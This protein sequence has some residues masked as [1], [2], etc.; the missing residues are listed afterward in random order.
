MANDLIK[1]LRYF[2]G[3]FLEEADFQAEQSY[4]IGHRRR[5]NQILWLK[6]GILDNG[7]EVKSILGKPTFILITKGVG[8]DQEGRELVRLN[9]W[10][11]SL[12]QAEG[13][14]VV[15]LS[16]DEEQTDQQFEDQD[17]SD[18]TRWQEVPQ[19]SF[20]DDLPKDRSQ[21]IVLALVKINADGEL[22]S[23]P[24]LSVRQ[25]AAARLPGDLTIGQDGNG[26]LHT[27]HIDGKDFSSDAQDHLFLNYA[28]NKDVYLGFGNG[29]RSSLYVSGKIGVGTQSPN[30]RLEIDMQTTNDVALRLVSS[31][32]GWGSGIQFQNTAA[33]TGR[34]FGIYSNPQGELHITDEDA[35]E[36]RL[37]MNSQKQLRIGG[38]LMPSVGN[39]DSAGIL[40]PLDPGG[41]SGDKAF[42][43]YF[44]ETGETTKLLIGCDNDIDDRISFQQLGAERLTIYGG[45]IGIG[46]TTPSAGKL[47]FANEAGN[48]IVV[49]DGGGADRYGFGLASGNLNAFIPTGSRFSLRKNGYEGDEVFSIQG[50]GSSLD[51]K[52]AS[53]EGPRFYLRNPLKNSVGSEWAIYNMTG[54]Y[55]DSLQF[56]NYNNSGGEPSQRLVISDDGNLGIGAFT[57]AERPLAGL[58]INKGNSNVVAL[59]ASSSG[60]G[61]GSGLQLRNDLAGKGYGIYAGADAS[62]HIV[63]TTANT[64][65]MVINSAG[66]ALFYGGLSWNNRSQIDSN[67]IVIGSLLICWGDQI[68]NIDTPPNNGLYTSHGTVAYPQTFSE[69]PTVSTSLNDPG[70][71]I[72]AGDTFVGVYQPSYTGFTLITKR[73]AFPALID[74]SLRRRQVSGSINVG[75]IAIGKKST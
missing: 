64:D 13:Q 63:D 5:A 69:L 14:K 17:V 45:N 73:I 31:G 30:A 27:R 61:W 60:P 1:R 42:I 11:E 22:A 65:R 6:A 10:E 75:W 19:V 43:R 18:N 7:F 35:R 72:D 47:Q 49:W 54:D 37:V 29:S 56:W 67:F 26:T 9:D 32:P 36:S 59:L 20:A 34:T 57:R 38:V 40:F 50:S 70:Y 15:V 12:P 48:K 58:H 21:L 4:H 33:G 8:V 41:G 44:A 52:Y 28:T 24:D 23:E 2:T 62:L 53:N 16:Y 68:I 74:S 3:Q 51:L 25:I 55:G 71:N 46:T 39:N 66:D